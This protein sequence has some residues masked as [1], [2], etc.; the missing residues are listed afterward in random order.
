MLNDLN[1]EADQQDSIEQSNT[2]RRSSRQCSVDTD[3]VA[4]TTLPRKCIFC[5]REKYQRNFCTRE[6]LTG[7]IQLRADKRVRKIA[8]EKNDTQIMKITS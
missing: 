4:T 7:C 3:N 5:N 8:K 6:E 1:F 2:L